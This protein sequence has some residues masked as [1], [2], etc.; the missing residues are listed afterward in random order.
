VAGDWIKMRNDLPNDPAVYKLSSI[1][2]LDRLAVVGRL[3]AFWSWADKHAV[4]GRVDGATSLVVDDITR[5]DGF[6]DALASVKWLEIGDDYVGIPNHDRHNGESAKER[7]LKNARQARWRDGKAKA[8]STDVD[9]APST[10]ASTREEKRREEKKE[11]KAAAPSFVLPDW[12]PA[13]AWAGYV[14]MRSKKKG[15]A[16]TIRARN[17]KVAELQKFKDAGHDLGAILDKSTANG[18]TDIYEPKG[19]P[20]AKQESYV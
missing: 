5:H 7:G 6:A 4:D 9:A 3:Y 10:E 11:D 2:N 20:S 1:T 16:M 15:G 8:P 13:E 12:I 14:E 17:L 19:N 18:W